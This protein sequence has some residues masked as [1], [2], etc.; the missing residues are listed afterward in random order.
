M[1]EILTQDEKIH[2]IG[3]HIKNAAY[4]LYQAEV[5]L[6]AENGTTNVDQVAIDGLLLQKQEWEEKIVALQAELALV[7]GV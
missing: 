6:I 3:Q 1:T 4:S 2:I 5:S 7:E